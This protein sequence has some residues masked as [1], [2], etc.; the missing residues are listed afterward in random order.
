MKVLTENKKGDDRKVT[1][2]GRPKKIGCMFVPPKPD[3]PDIPK[4]GPKQ[5]C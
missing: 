2:S 1:V 5:N 3:P 4:A